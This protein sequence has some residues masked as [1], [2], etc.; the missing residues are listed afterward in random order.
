M[1]DFRCRAGKTEA[2]K[3][4]MKFLCYSTGNKA[5]MCNGP[6]PSLPEVPHAFCGSTRI[7][8]LFAGRGKG[9]VT[10]MSTALSNGGMSMGG[11]KNTM[12]D[13]VDCLMMR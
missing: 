13:L 9:I 7:P 4:C 1:E 2:S 6:R 10:R 11:T 5:A 3:Y 8:I 12:G